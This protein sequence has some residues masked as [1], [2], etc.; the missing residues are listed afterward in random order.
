[1]NLLKTTLAT[2]TVG[3]M[4]MSCAGGDLPPVEE[5]VDPYI[6]TVAPML[7]TTVPL[8]H[9]PHSMVRVYPVTRMLDRYLSDNIYG[10]GL[11][12]PSYRQGNVSS[13]MATSGALEVNAEQ[14]ASF[15]DKTTEEVH[16][17]SHKMHFMD[18]DIDAEWTTTERTWVLN[19]KF[20]RR[21]NGNIIF[22]INNKG[23]IKVADNHTVCGYE[24]VSYAR[25]YFYA[26]ISSPSQTCGTFRH[27]DVTNAT[28]V[29][30][31]KAGAWFSGE[32][33]RVEVRIGLSFISEEQ[34]KANLERENLD[35]TFEHIKSCSRS[36]WAEQLGRIKV[37]GG[38]ER[39]RRIFYT[40]LYRNFERM[41]DQSEY[42][43]YYSGFDSLVHEDERPFYNDD[44]NWDTYRN[45]HAL[46]MLLNPRM[47]ADQLQSVVRMYEQS[48]WVPNFPAL[49]HRG[50]GGKG[51]GRGGESLLLEP[52]VGNHYASVVAEAIRKGVVDFDIRK[53]YEGL[54]HNALL[55]T[56]VPWRMGPATE[57]DALYDKLGYFPGIAKDQKETYAFVDDSW[58][59]R[60]SVS[61]T[62]EHSYD[63]WCLAQIAR[64]LGCQ[65]DYELFMSRS[66]YY[67]NLWNPD[68]R[69]FAPKNSE[70]QWIQP[71]NPELSEGYGAR[72][73]FT[74]N[75]AWVHQ[76]NVQHDIAKLIELMGGKQK[77]IEKLDEAYNH[78]PSIGKYRYLA[79]MPD[80]TGLHG[81]LPAGNE[82]S[83]HVPYL[84]NYAGAAWKTQYRVRQIME[85][86]FDDKPDGL[87]GDEDGG[88]LCA[89]YVFSAMG[90]YPVSPATGMYA[91]GSPLFEKVEIALPD[92]KTFRIVAEGCS[93]RNKYIR[94][95]R[96]NGQSLTVPFLSHDDIVAGGELRLVM[97]DVPH[98]EWGI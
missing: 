22:S 27:G 45:T 82:P 60:Q 40:S 76:F 16:P 8:V 52:M 59:K 35:F 12:L 30:G 75:S 64:Y 63:D 4:L 31:N 1:M 87:S 54:K 33:D 37:E 98:R 86:W 9:R 58:E 29:E 97:D 50:K 17:W 65:E 91:I 49:N 56:M 25:Q 70:G 21:D 94:S 66:R 11:N 13:V 20:N 93:K 23:R 55:G 69:F 36:I 73:Y 32:Y 38:T 74:E 5:Y 7:Q 28:V 6:G 61:V 3:L 67:L 34:A 53:A 72:Y 10:I 89:W 68:I 85:M 42:G 92:G 83:F 2:C 46:Q 62:L 79:L 44:W 77:F 51:I 47:K 81:M 19:L 78:T 43:R 14:M 39:E 24:Q 88:A 26:V 71:F 15:V 41:A 48:G 90:F 80:A 18:H 57:L 96:L 84:Y 95:A